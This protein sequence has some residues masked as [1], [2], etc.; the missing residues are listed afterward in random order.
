[1]SIIKSLSVGNGDTFYI[2]HGSDNFT[3]IDCCLS[4][5]NRY[6]IVREIKSASASKGI[7]RFISTHPDDDHI[8]GLEYLDSEMGLRN[9][10][11]V[12]NQ[13]TKSNESVDFDRYC[14][15][16]DS[17][18]AFYIKKGCSRKWMNLA[19]DD[20][21]SSGITI[22]WPITDNVHYLTAL[23]NAAKGESPNNIS[24]IL[25]YKLEDGVTALWMGDLETGF[26][27]LIASELDLP[28][29]DILFAP[30]HGRESGKIPTDLLQ[31]MNPKII[32][33]G[34][35]PSGNIN[36][37]QDYNTI[38]QNSAGDITIDCVTKKIHIHVISETYSVDFLKD[39]GISSASNYLGTQYL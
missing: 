22:S 20:R 27:E 19:D 7:I 33:I 32:I 28:E 9:F 26:M 17:D 6:K 39:D 11:C 30:H 3:I 24:P 13:A 37:Y 15:L 23:E 8:R 34:E 14:E 31:A 12:E 1:M 29:V 36:Y 5:D 18:K 25:K 21:G 2:Q 38:T 35:A 10:Y 16:R 4:D